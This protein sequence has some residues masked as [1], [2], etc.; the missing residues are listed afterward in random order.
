MYQHSIIYHQAGSQS[1]RMSY[2]F[3]LKALHSGHGIFSTQTTSTSRP[4]TSLSV[5]FIRG[6]EEAEAFS[7]AD[8]GSTLAVF[9]THLAL[10][11]VNPPGMGA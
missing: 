2:V 3:F 4:R 5:H 7:P 10:T 1:V 9:Q 8:G 11:T 6:V